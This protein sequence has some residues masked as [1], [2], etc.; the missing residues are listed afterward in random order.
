MLVSSD[1]K[2]VHI[3]PFP[4]VIAATMDQLDSPLFLRGHWRTRLPKGTAAV[5]RKWAMKFRLTCVS[6]DRPASGGLHS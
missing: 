3:S 1:D 6:A 2:W 4:A 5:Y